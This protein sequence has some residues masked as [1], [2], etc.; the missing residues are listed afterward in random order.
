MNAGE[1]LSHLHCVLLEMIE[2]V[3][4]LCRAHGITYFLTG[5]SA[6]GAARCQGFVPW[7]DDLDVMMAAHDYR[8]FLVVCANELDT[9][10]F[11]LDEGGTGTRPMPFSKLRRNGTRVWEKQETKTIHHGIFIDIFP[12][13]PVKGNRFMASLQ[14]LSS[15]IVVAHAS[16]KMGPAASGAMKR[17]AQIIGGLVPWRLIGMIRQFAEEGGRSRAGMLVNLYHRGTFAQ[18]VVPTEALGRPVFRPFERLDLMTPEHIQWY[19]TARFGEYWSVPPPENEREP[20]HVRRVEIDR[21]VHP[22]FRETCRDCC[23]PM[24]RTMLRSVKRRRSE[25]LSL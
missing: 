22:T 21:Y 1:S 2:H 14:W 15:R 7:D 16:R 17:A 3:D 9:T 20:S 5:G 18:N 12:M 24:S 6:L 10:K 23:W 25:K 8:R 11:F 4:G 13:F 19:L